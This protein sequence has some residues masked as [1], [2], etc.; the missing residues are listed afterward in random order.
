MNAGLAQAIAAANIRDAA[1][2]VIGN[3][4]ANPLSAASELRD[5]LSRQASAAV[6]WTRSIEFLAGSGVNVFIEIGPGQALTG[7]IKRIVKGATLLSIGNAADVEKAATLVR[8][9]SLL[10]E[11]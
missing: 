3:I 4:D 9:M 11:S 2:P 10:H 1:I 6:Q 8:Q 5:E 7:M